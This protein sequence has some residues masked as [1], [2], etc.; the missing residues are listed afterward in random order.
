MPESG[1]SPNVSNTDCNYDIVSVSH[2]SR[3]RVSSEMRA[4]ANPDTP[5]RVPL[6]ERFCNLDRLLQAMQA[7]NV[8]GLVA[9]SMLNVFYLTGFNSI[10]HKSDEPRVADAQPPGDSLGPDHHS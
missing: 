7:R 4:T 10:A 5:P 3:T 1:V 9:T 6:P 2:P 8:D